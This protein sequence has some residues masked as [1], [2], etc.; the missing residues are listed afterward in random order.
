MAFLNIVTLPSKI[1]EIRH[2]VCK[3]TWSLYLHS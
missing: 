2:S 3:K 1:D